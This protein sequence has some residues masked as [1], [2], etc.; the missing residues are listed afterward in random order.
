[1]GPTEYRFVTAWDFV[2]PIEDVWREVGDPMNWS[3]F[4][5]GLERVHSLEAGDVDGRDATYELVFKSFLP[6]TLRLE[7]RIVSIDPPRHLKM[8]TSGELEGTAVFDL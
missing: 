5:T 8:E 4:W 3:N 1:M 2:A 6:Y 7:A